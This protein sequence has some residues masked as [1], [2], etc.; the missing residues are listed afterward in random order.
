MKHLKI[1]PKY[2][3]FLVG[4]LLVI[5]VVQYALLTGVWSPV[6]IVFI[7]LQV[8]CYLLLAVAVFRGFIQRSRLAWLVTQIML[9]A[10]F[11][12]SLLCSTLS[13]VF[14]LKTQGIGIMLGAA[15]GVA[16]LDGLLLGFLFSLPVCE[17]FK[18]RTEAQ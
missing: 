12:F 3:Q 10:M 7:L 11:A 5:M 6:H 8:F 2:F 4:S 15:L 13:A 14:A 18:P 17:Y 9:T 16:V 1:S